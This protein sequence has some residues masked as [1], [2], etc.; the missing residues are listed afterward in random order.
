MR[1]TEF[2]NDNGVC[3]ITERVGKYYNYPFIMF[4]RAFIR[5]ILSK[6]RDRLEWEDTEHKTWM[7]EDVLL[8]TSASS[9]NI[10]EVCYIPSEKRFNLVL[11]KI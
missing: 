2:L 3:V 7:K 11:S 4:I 6:V 1:L 9:L 5:R 8:A 10:E